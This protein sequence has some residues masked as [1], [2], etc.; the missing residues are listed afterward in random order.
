MDRISLCQ[1]N[2]PGVCLSPAGVPDSMLLRLKEMW[3]LCNFHSRG[4]IS[5]E[6]YG[7]R[8]FAFRE[9]ALIL[10]ENREEKDTLK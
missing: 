9:L 4:M 10:C 5:K 6:E 8:E 7:R 2:A 1:R 3:A